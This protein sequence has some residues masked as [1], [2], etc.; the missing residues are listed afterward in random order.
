M[1]SFQFA[2][3]ANLLLALSASAANI[4]WGTPHSPGVSA[5][6]AGIGFTEPP[7]KGYTDLLTGAGH[8]VTRFLSPV[9]GSNL[10][11]DAGQLAT[12]NGADLVIIG[13]SNNSASFD[14]VNEVNSWNTQVTKPLIL[15]SGYIAR[16]NRLGFTTGTTI[17]DITGPTR[18]VAQ[19]PAHPIF[20]G[21]TLNGS[22]ETGPILDLV[23][24]PVVGPARG[25]SIN[26]NT[27]V[28]GGTPLAAITADNTAVPNGPVIAEFPAGTASSFAGGG[29][30]ANKRLLFT[31]GSR[32]AAAGSNSDAAGI[33]DLSADGRTMFLNAVNYMANTV[34]LVPGDTDGDGVVE[35]TDFD[36]IK[37]NFRKAVTMRTQGD[38]VPNGV[39]D[40]NDFRQW[41]NAFLGA[42]GS[43]D[44][45]D[46]AFLTV[47]EPGTA[48]L[49]VLAAFGLINRCA[50]HR[51]QAVV[52]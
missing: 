12:L 34:P 37:N 40:F 24:N 8:T 11:L 47:P 43:A 2:V 45:L 4:V 29:N 14:N 5:L 33:I 32:E 46:L 25:A 16:N 38:L 41:K 35:L 17:P 7:D 50:R 10:A 19:N 44:G 18:F 51:R 39:V 1:K 42:G 15:T 21:V 48:L 13:R 22:N 6:A 52:R 27:L 9:A 20:A 26:N 36:P 23:P 49:L 3:A 30:F 31:T 28:T